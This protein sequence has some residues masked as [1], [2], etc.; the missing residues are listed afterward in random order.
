M[1]DPLSPN[2]KNGVGRLVTDRFDFQKH[3]DGDSFRHKASQIDLDTPL[4]VSAV[5]Y[6]NVQD[7]LAALSAIVAPPVVS[8]ATTSSK[9]IVQLTGDI[10]GIAT[11]VQVKGLRGRLVSSAPPST[12]QVLTYNGTQWEPQTVITPLVFSGDLSGDYLSQKVIHITGVSGNIDFIANNIYLNDSLDTIITLKDKDIAGAAHTVTL[13]GQIN[14]NASGTGGN[15]IVSSGDSSGSGGK[16]FLWSGSG[17]T[18]GGDISIK[19]G[20]GQFGVSGTIDIFTEFGLN[21]GSINLVAGQATD[22]AGAGGNVSL[23]AGFASGSSGVGGNIN[24]TAGNSSSSGTGGGGNVNITSGNGS[25]GVG[26]NILLT[27]S[28][29]NTHGG[30]IILNAGISSSG[31]F[32]GNIILT[33][34]SSGVS[35]QH[36][37]VQINDHGGSVLVKAGNIDGTTVVGL[38]GIN[39]ITSAMI[40]PADS[41]TGMVFIGNG[42]AP[43]TDP[44]SYMGSGGPLEGVFLYSNN[45]RL[46]VYEGESGSSNSLRFQVRPPYIE[47]QYIAFDGTTPALINLVSGY[48]VVSTITLSSD[49]K[50]DDEI[51]IKAYGAMVCADN[52]SIGSLRFNI[53]NPPSSIL[54]TYYT[55][56]PSVTGTHFF[57]IYAIYKLPS[58]FTGG[59]TVEISAYSAYGSSSP[60]TVDFQLLTFEATAIRP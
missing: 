30:N 13:S 43:T 10:D 44:S 56:P 5:T 7:I 52:S 57:N 1:S 45:G 54:I 46:F 8:D 16:L 34:G 50:K 39:P 11:N 58:N 23:T 28:G 2:Y 19:S 53:G 12:G 21:S 55:T 33:P 31:G 32:G 15:L 14:S 25:S 17:D 4:V 49:L 24:L 9:G 3:V 6:D 29:G 42:T 47:R 37:T 40:D 18:N 41:A 38:G 20:Y 26:G 35:Y 51:L 36:G 48:Q 60:H 59:I 22:T 27:A